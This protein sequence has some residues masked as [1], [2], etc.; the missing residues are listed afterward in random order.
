MNPSSSSDDIFSMSSARDVNE[1]VLV[2]DIGGTWFRAGI[3][4][5]GGIE[6]L[7]R[8][9]AVSFVNSRAT[10]A[11]LQRELV[12]FIVDNALRY[13]RKDQMS[14]ASV[15]VGAAVNANTG[16]IVASAPL[17]GPKAPELDLTAI[18]A[19]EVPGLRWHVINDVTALAM[20]L[21]LRDFPPAT[22]AASALTVSSGIAYRTIDLQTGEIPY[23]PRYGLQGEIGHLPTELSWH[24]RRLNAVCDCG[25]P[26]HVSAFSSGRGIAALLRTLTVHNGL[27][28]D[29]S[30]MR[31]FVQEVTAGHQSAIE[32]LDLFT[33]PIAMVLLYQA[34]LNPQVGCTVLSGGVVERLGRA[35]IDSLVR[36]LNDLGLYGIS[37][38]DREYF[39]RSLR[40]GHAD[41]LDALRGAAVYAHGFC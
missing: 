18:L 37:T 24:G 14:H 6:V 27:R 38:T 11:K 7:S 1:P 30:L 19:A 12:D 9:P 34:T 32:F 31:G 4:R 15:S 40:L 21:I 33:R 28:T 35:Y 29:H 17:W 20:A 2:F 36:N 41:G 22:K 10:V 16:R 26:G 39:N 25:S 13:A 5:D 8:V 3:Y 23:D